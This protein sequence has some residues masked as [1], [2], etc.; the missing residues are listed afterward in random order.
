MDIKYIENI[1]EDLLEL[2]DI[3]IQKQYW[4]NKNPGHVSSYTELMCRL[5]DDDCFDDF[6]GLLKKNAGCFQDQVKQIVDLHEK[7]NLYNEKGKTDNNILSDTK[8]WEIVKLSKVVFNNWPV[9][10][11]IL[12]E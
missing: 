2:S 3:K 5:F 4:N 11:S 8:W 12:N 6:V 10:V 1:Y 7:L 9:Y